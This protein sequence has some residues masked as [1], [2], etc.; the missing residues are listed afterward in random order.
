MKKFKDL[1]LNIKLFIALII[2]LLIGILLR[3][4]TIKKD[5]LRSFNFF[6]KDTEQ[7]GSIS[8]GTPQQN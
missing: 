8:T 4:N 5:I 7:T 1:S 2:V 3:W 6:S